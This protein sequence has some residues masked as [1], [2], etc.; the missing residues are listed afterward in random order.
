MVARGE[1]VERGP[2][3]P[4]SPR[5]SRAPA[6]ASDRVPCSTTSSPTPSSVTT[7]MSI[8]SSCRPD[9]HRVARPSLPTERLPATSVQPVGYGD[10]AG[11]VGTARAPAPS[12]AGARHPHGRQRRPARDPGHQ[13]RLRRRAAQA[14]PPL[15]ARLL[16]RRRA[17]GH[18]RH[19][20]LGLALAAGA[21]RVRRARSR[22]GRSPATTSRASSS[23][24]CCRRRSAATSCGSAARPRTSARARPRSRPSR[25][26]GSAASSRSRCICFFGFLVDPSLLE[27][28]T[29]WVA[30]L[31]SGIALA[32]LAGILLLAAHPRMA[33]RFQDH[34]N[35]M[36][37]IG[38]TPRRR[39]AAARASREPRSPCSAPR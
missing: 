15:H 2:R 9:A 20:P 31:V 6:A 18:D 10:G 13:D 37:F 34:D 12:P 36:R 7:R 16:R 32:A 5:R 23:A 33:G 39:R 1:R 11:R 21:P 29:A 24:T 38:A 28:S 17:H 14:A 27:S 25:S 30:I 35:W 22:C 4:P 19:R 3:S 26:N 8:P